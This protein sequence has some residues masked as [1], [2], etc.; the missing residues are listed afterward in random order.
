MLYI[1]FESQLNRI[2]LLPSSVIST[3]SQSTRPSP[4]TNS[5]PIFARFPGLQRHSQTLFSFWFRSKNSTTAPVS[6]FTPKILAGITLVSFSIRQSPSFKYS[7]SCEK[8]LCF[9]LPLFL[10][11]TIKREAFL[12][13]IGVWAISS[14]GK[15]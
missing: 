8:I 2:F 7:S 15:S 9:I 13:S 14:S 10:S 6:F 12:G 11:S 1:S 3:T 4:K 5:V